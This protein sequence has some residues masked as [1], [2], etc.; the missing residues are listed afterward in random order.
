VPT[1]KTLQP[2]LQ[3]PASASTFRAGA[4]GTCLRGFTASRLS[5]SQ[6]CH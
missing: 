5:S 6:Q 1:V 3:A 2:G 4:I